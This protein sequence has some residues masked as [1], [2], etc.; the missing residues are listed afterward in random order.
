MAFFEAYL[1]AFYSLF[2]IIAKVTP[3]IYDRKAIKKKIPDEYFE[4]QKNFFI[5]NRDIDENYTKYLE[6]QTIWYD[7]IVCNRHAISHNISVFLGF[8]KEQ[9]ESIHIP[10]KNTFL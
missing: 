6:E 4:W 2:Q 7:D 1:N 5:T 10:K 9:I 8:G 3:Y